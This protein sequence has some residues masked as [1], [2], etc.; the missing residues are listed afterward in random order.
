[1]NWKHLP[2]LLSGLRIALMPVALGLAAE[3]SRRWFVGLLAAS[4]V[5]DAL[6]GFFAR[7]WHAQ[8]DLGRRLDSAGDYVTLLMGLAGIALLWPEIVHREWRWVA[9]GLGAF[10][11]VVAYGFLRLGRAPCYHTWASKTLAVALA[12]SLVPLLAG[13]AAEPFRAVMALQVLAGVE[14]LLIAMIA[15]WHTGEMPTAWHAWRQRQE[16]ER[17]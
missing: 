16:R 11:A 17:K 15:P 10:F 2:N 13:W 6:D 12:L 8:S 14:E 1:M 3:G 7:R 4:L 5:T 9:A